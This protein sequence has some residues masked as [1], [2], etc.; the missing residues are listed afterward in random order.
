MKPIL[1]W[2]A[3]GCAG[4]ATGWAALTPRTQQ[5]RGLQQPRTVTTDD[6]AFILLPPELIAS[7]TIEKVLPSPDGKYVLVQR[8]TLKITSS[9]LTPDGLKAMEQS[10]P[11]G[12]RQLIIWDARTHDSRIMWRGGLETQFSELAW[13]RGSSIALG[14][15]YQFIQADP[16]VPNSTAMIAQS[17]IRISATSDRAQ[18]TTIAPQAGFATLNIGP[19]LPVAI[20]ERD[21][22]HAG[23][24][25]EIANSPALT[26]IK[27]DGRS[28][29]DIDTVGLPS[30]KVIH[31]DINGNPAIIA[32]HQSLEQKS[33]SKSDTYSIDIRTGLLKQ[34]VGVFK[35]FDKPQKSD[36][37]LTNPKLALHV[38]SSTIK[39]RETTEKIGVLWLEGATNSDSP[40][41]LVASNAANGQFLYG[42]DGIVYDSNG[43]LWFTPMARVSLDQYK[44]MREAA[45]RQVTISNAKQLGLG[46]L[47]YSQDY[48]EMLPDPN[49]INSKVDPYIKCFK[50]RRI[51][52]DGFS[53][54]ETRTYR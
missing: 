1:L 26:L 41:A 29:V 54:L 28:T 36:Q 31:W 2:M 16:K 8:L 25:G 20:L 14:L 46:L 34:Y 51:D 53:F 12:E 30:F 39:S 52:C 50:K 27:A 4:A 11:R 45:Q 18:T 9:M 35:D 40:R 37:V 48:D 15:T 5:G 21:P 13:L 10:P 33:I 3:I 19:V 23:L 24:N 22:I 43:A 17:L 6:Q 47:M 7:P 32:F 49:G 42:G 44:Q 38:E